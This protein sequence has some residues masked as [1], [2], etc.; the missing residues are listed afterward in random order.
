[1]QPKVIPSLFD[2][3]ENCRKIEY[4]F[5]FDVGKELGELVWCSG[6]IVDVSNGIKF[7]K[8]RWFSGKTSA[9]RVYEKRLAADVE[10]DPV[11][12][13]D[14]ETSIVPFKRGS[15]NRNKEGALRLYY[16]L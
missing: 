13:H 7:K 12:G 3:M 15:F 10:W 8:S 4:L 1:M 9:S 14:Q 5:V 11:G 6:F 16:E 2:L